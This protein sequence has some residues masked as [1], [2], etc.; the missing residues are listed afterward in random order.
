M[1]DKQK[2]L[3]Q[4]LAALHDGSAWDNFCDALKNAGK[5]VQAD[6]VPNTDI[7][8][9]E[10]YRYLA[11]LTRCALDSYL[12]A[13]DNTAPEFS[14][15]VHETI[16]M[17]MDNPDNVY[18]SAPVSGKHR[19]RITGNRGTVHYLGFG[20]Q[21]GGYGKTGNLETT[22]YVES[23]DM[24]IADDGAFELIASL[25][26]PEGAA[27]WLPLREDSRLIQIRQ[28][29]LDHAN[30]ILAAVKIERID[31]DGNNINQ[32]RPFA[33]A[34]VAPALQGAAQFVAGTASVFKK[35]TD[36]FAPHTNAL[37]RF[38]PDVA[39][40]AGGDP[41]IA[42]YHSAFDLQE[43]EALL[44]TLQPPKCD[45]WNFQLANYWLESLDYRYFPIHINQHTAQYEAD[46][47]V[48]VLVSKTDPASVGVEIGNWLNTCGRDM[49]TMCVRWIRAD[50]HPVPQVEVVKLADLKG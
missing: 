32:P 39:F 7:D 17:G 44:V 45:F 16:K 30:E 20:S 10:G 2:M 19:Y 40:K 46:G 1:D 49:G 48:R 14:R 13:A 38:D 12:E 37:P 9:A 6:G 23:D 36:G 28:T 35:W 8:K 50:K 15:P 21:A 18:M 3:E 26:K 29:R 34:R 5:L 31:A 25:E 47:S 11:R 43:G 22:G 24:Q 42:Y 27:N 33:P 4:S 41:N